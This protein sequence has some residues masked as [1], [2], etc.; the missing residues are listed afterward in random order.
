MK[1]GFRDMLRL[2]P[3][4]LSIVAFAGASAAAH[5]ANGEA[6]GSN[7]YYSESVGVK[8]PNEHITGSTSSRDA[9]GVPLKLR[10]SKG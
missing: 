8:T 1:R 5:A 7:V 4:A 3:P 10:T 6:K 9:Q 2:L